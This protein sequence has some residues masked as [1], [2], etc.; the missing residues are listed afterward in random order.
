VYAVAEEK[1]NMADQEYV[2]RIALMLPGTSEGKDCFAFSVLNSGKQKGFVWAWNERIEA[3]KPKVPSSVVVGIRVANQ[4][5]K[6]AL[7]ACG[8]EKFFIEPHYNGYPAILV[9]LP[10]IAVDELEELLV[11]A[12]LCQAP[13][14]LVD[15]WQ[16][17]KHD[18]LRSAS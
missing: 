10:L 1:Q 7:L 16:R 15:I 4:S 5:D 6:E 13:R 3:K 17:E 18:G 2:R 11:D 12:W 9:W 14:A 8:E